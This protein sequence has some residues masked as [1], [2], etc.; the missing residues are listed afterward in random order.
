MFAGVFMNRKIII[1]LIILGV[2]LLAAGPA[3]AKEKVKIKIST[4]DNVYANKGYIII[5]LVDSH[6]KAIKSKGTIHY[7]VTDE[8]GYYKW[9]YHPYKGEEHLKY[10]MGKYKVK[11]KFDGDSKYKS[12]K[13]TKSVT[14]K[15]ESIDPYTYYDNH[16]WGENS[17]VD[18]YIFDNYW[19]EE[20]YDELDDPENEVWDI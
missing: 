11:V 12:A 18:E 8:Y 19:Y 17:K 6:G 3:F 14:V 13:K 9:A 2:F 1:I 5:K 20:I 10:N 16:N 7:N 15:S 4:D